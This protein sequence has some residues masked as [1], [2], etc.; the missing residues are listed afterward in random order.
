MTEPSEDAVAFD[1]FLTGSTPEVAEIARALRVA[2]LPDPH[3]R[4]EGTGK[5]ARHLK[6]RTVAETV[7]PWLEAAVAAQLAVRREPAE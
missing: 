1:R 4:I 6:V 5:R 2:V 3:G 7:A